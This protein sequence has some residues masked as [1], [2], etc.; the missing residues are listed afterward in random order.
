MLVKPVDARKNKP[1]DEV[2]AKSTQDVKSEGRVVIPKGSKIIGHITEAKARAKGQAES[3]VGIVFDRAI[4]KSGSEMPLALGIQAV[5]SG[6]ANAAA[7]DSALAGGSASGS[8]YGRA[9]AGGVVGGVQSTAGSVVNTAGSAAGTT[10]NT[11]SATG[12]SV[13]GHLSSASHGA[14][15]LP[16]LV[17]ATDASN[18]TNDSVISS[19]STNVRLDSGTEMILSVKNP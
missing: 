15:G 13:A 2:V 1:G 11:A 16:G 6:R 9:S 19:K 4:L 5:G 8:S 7:D 12:G 18:S 14:S 17:L 10:L 3:T